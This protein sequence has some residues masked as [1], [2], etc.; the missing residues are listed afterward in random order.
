MSTTRFGAAVGLAVL[1]VGCGSETGG[2][3]RADASSSRGSEL[4]AW[5]EE[6]GIGPVEEEV[7]LGALDEA[8][9]DR[10]EAIFRSKCSACHKP[11]ERY[12]GPAL[13]DVLDRRSPEYA[14]NMMLNPGEMVQRHPEARALLAQFL[15]PMPSQNLTEADARALL[16][17]L[18]EL[19]E[20][21]GAES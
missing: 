19:N 1:L 10:G 17:Y 15:T 12:V 2:E 8:L 3:A 4:T 9:A 20:E 6:H 14:M 18:R 7:E 13:A 16:E 11:D 5:E 21:S